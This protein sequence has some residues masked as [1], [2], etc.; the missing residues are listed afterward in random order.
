MNLEDAAV[1][2]DAAEA[3][4]YASTP[5][6]RALAE[7]YI[8]TP[9][10]N[11]LHYYESGAGRD[12]ILIHGALV[13]ADDPIIALHDALV[14]RLHI[15]AIDRRGHGLSPRPRGQ[16]SLWMQAESIRNAANQVGLDRP[17]LVGLAMVLRSRSPKR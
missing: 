2:G 9:E 3:S 5:N 10:G 11:R 12:V 4:T 8:N 17:V 1:L 6:T 13:T 16:T 7:H 15:V 14:L